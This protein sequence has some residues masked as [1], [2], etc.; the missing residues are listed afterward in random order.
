MA[1]DTD[2]RLQYQK[3]L[4]TACKGTPVTP[5]ELLRELVYTGYKKYY[6]ID[7]GLDDLKS[8]VADLVDS[9]EIAELA[10]RNNGAKPEME[11]TD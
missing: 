8:I 1:K 4:E 5:K 2:E 11:I 10:N 3:L 6:D 7:L 9:K